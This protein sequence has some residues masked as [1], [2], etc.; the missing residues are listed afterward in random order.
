MLNV[1]LHFAM[2]NGDKC[3]ECN[4]HNYF[5]IS[6]K[7]SDGYLRQETHWVMLRDIKL[8]KWTVN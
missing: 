1:V 8:A 7:N 3:G 6:F 2:N 4:R 5:Q